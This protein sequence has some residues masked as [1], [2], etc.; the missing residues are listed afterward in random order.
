MSPSCTG[1]YIL[2]YYVSEAVKQVCTI[3]FV[4][5]GAFTRRVKNPING[6]PAAGFPVLATGG[7]F[8]YGLYER[9][10]IVRQYLRGSGKDM[11]HN[12]ETLP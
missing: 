4:T 7:T 11:Q 2:R 12:R 8:V 6:S 5:C 3:A 10:A 1:E 9:L